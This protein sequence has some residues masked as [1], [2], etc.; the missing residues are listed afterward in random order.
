[1]EQEQSRSFVGHIDDFTKAKG[2]FFG[3]FMA[4]PLLR[5]DLVEVAWQEL[6][7]LTPAPAQAHFHKGAVEI[8][9]LIRGWMKLTIDGEQY[10]L[11]KKDFYIIWPGS[12][13]ADIT[14]GEDTELICIKAPSLPND[15]FAATRLLNPSARR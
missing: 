9:I 3:A 14:T 15:K 10:E 4:E 6:P 5:S 13:V 11:R 12:I 2:W 8:N 1:M 7:N